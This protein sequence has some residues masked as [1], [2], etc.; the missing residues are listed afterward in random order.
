MASLV[1]LTD[2]RR[3]WRPHKF[4]RVTL[5]CKLLLE[6]PVAKLLDFDTPELAR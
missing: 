6:F 3:E 5:G 4:E 2:A 1:L